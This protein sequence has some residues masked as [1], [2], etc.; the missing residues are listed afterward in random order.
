VKERNKILKL[1]ATGKNTKAIYLKYKK[2]FWFDDYNK[3]FV[4]QILFTE[5]K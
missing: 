2:N 1:F 3:D 4:Y 5:T